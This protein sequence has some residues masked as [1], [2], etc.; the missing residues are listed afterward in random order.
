MIKKFSSPK[1]EYELVADLPAG[2]AGRSEANPSSLQFPI[3]GI[4]Q[5]RSN[6]F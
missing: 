5:L 1:V 4:I 6:I 3:G 2:K